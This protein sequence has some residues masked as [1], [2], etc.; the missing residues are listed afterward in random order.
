MLH[1]SFRRLKIPHTKL[2]QK[3]YKFPRNFQRRGILLIHVKFWYPKMRI[4]VIQVWAIN[5]ANHG[6]YVHDSPN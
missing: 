4:F 5:A 1:L 6:K 3:P 2:E